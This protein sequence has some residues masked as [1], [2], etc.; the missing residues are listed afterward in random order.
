MESCLALDAIGIL[1]LRGNAQ[2]AHHVVDAVDGGGEASG[3]AST[4]LHELA[5][6]RCHTIIDGLRYHKAKTAMRRM[7]SRV[8]CDAIDILPLRSDVQLAHHMV[9]AV[10]GSG[11]ASGPASTTRHES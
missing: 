4:T 9:D 8:A 11:E 5:L 1:P 6:A 2:L 7:E 10:Q 3:P